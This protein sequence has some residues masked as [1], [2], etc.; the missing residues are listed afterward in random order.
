VPEQRRAVL[1]VLA[2]AA[3]AGYQHE[4]GQR[5]FAINQRE[6]SHSWSAA[7]SGSMAVIVQGVLPPDDEAR[8]QSVGVSA[9]V[10]SSTP[11]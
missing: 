4:R 1:E 3:G 2:V 6:A 8:D 10:R 9:S 11:R 7:R 5:S